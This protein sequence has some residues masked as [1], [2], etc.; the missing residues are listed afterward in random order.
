[1]VMDCVP[2][3]LLRILLIIVVV[4]LSFAPSAQ[5]GSQERVL[6]SFSGGADGGNPV[7]KLIFDK[8]GNLYGTT[9]NGGAYN[10]GT[11]FMLKPSLGRSTETVLYSFT[12]GADGGYPLADLAFDSRGNLY[13]TAMQGGASGL[14]VIF[15]L[16][17]SSAGS[18][19]ETVLHSFAGGY[20]DGTSPS[21]GLTPDQSG[22]FYGIA[23]AGQFS[24]GS[25]FKLTPSGG[26][27]TYT[28]LVTWGSPAG[29]TFDSSSNLYG[30]TNGTQDGSVFEVLA[31]SYSTVDV[32]YAFVG[33]SDGAN[34]MYGRLIFD[35]KGNL[36]GTTQQGGSG[37][38]TVYEV[39]FNAGVWTESVLHSF[40]RS[41]GA[42]P[43]CGLIFDP[44]GRLIGTTQEG[45]TYGLGTVFA[46]AQN[47]TGRWIETVLHDFAG[48]DDGAYPI[49]GVVLDSKG[50]IYGTAPY[51][52]EHNA[53]VVFAIE[54]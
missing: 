41:N 45:G 42:F 11:V 39:A 31:P 14:G 48:G 7:A 53:G 19:T 51:G 24:R 29:L 1:V 36:Y 28:V 46:L 35:A 13:G 30:T 54:P 18:W 17:H 23:E 44:K 34:P 50:R 20:T 12:G 2:R 47:S 52:G 22:D 15:E 33:G 32:V 40:A 43:L 6:Y 10:A 25:A 8:G 3:S 4:T 26:I 37:F 49:N 16:S 21:A 27:W 38:G 9:S 5:A